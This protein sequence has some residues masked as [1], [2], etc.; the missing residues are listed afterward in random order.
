MSFI[1]KLSWE[2]KLIF[3]YF[4]H[5]W[6]C[7][8]LTLGPCLWFVPQTP[9]KSSLDG[10][11]SCEISSDSTDD[12]LS[13]G[14]RT[15]RQPRIVVIG[16]GLAGLAAT[17]VLLKNGFTDVTVLEASDHIGG[18][19]HS[20]EHG[21]RTCARWPPMFPLNSLWMWAFSQ[22]DWHCSRAA[23]SSAQ[24]HVIDSTNCNTCIW[25]NSVHSFLIL[26]KLTIGFWLNHEVLHHT[27][28]RNSP[29]THL[30]LV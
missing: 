9:S 11:Q 19:V 26:Q 29:V 2:N 18:R 5:Y 21:E 1:G 16:A 3:F 24:R 17:K 13:S 14:L 25:Y 4:P 12:P 10:M 23:G 15:H 30:K 6:T 20:R 7:H 27:P 28:S 22:N 8:D